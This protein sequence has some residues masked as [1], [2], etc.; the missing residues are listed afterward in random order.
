MLV[1]QAAPCDTTD[2]RHR[3]RRGP[4]GIRRRVEDD[5][6]RLAVRLLRVEDVVDRQLGGRFGRLRVWHGALL[7]WGVGGV[8]RRCWR[9]PNGRRPPRSDEARPDL[10]GPKP[11]VLWGRVG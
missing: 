3:D 7:R 5:R 10:P 6:D 8:M 4:R 11:P 9:A 2:G 1:E